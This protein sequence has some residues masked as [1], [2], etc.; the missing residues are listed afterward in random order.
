MTQGRSD[1]RME[2]LRPDHPHIVIEFKQGEDTT[3]LK[4]Q[5]LS[6][7]KE[8]RYYAGLQGKVLCLGVAH[9]KKKCEIMSEIVDE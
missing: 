2:S 6:Q 7:I 4:S 9:N 5:A 3:K 8:K 1:I